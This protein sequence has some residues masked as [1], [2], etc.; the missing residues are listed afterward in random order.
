[1]QHFK[2]VNKVPMMCEELHFG[3]G[4]PFAQKGRHEKRG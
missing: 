2:K 4:F 3:H 1:M